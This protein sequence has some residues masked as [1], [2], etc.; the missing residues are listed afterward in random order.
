MKIE[1]ELVDYPTISPKE[2][3]VYDRV[4]S[5]LEIKQFSNTNVH[6]MKEYSG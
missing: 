6:C 5:Q 1:V 2:S 4:T 3:S